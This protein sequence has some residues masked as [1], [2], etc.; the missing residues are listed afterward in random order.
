VISAV[1]AVQCCHYHMYKQPFFT[2]ITVKFW[3]VKM[4]TEVYDSA[5]ML[6]HHSSNQSAT[7]TASI[8]AAISLQHTQRHSHS[9][10]HATTVSATAVISLQ[11]TQRQSQQ[12]SVCNTPS[13]IVTPWYML[14]LHHLN[15]SQHDTLIYNQT[16][17]PYS[18]NNQ[19]YIQTPPTQFCCTALNDVIGYVILH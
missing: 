13:V 9:V 10:I 15:D 18:F 1:L 11:H 8:T 5:S 17:T 4:Q 12:Q 16:E 19:S 3:I 7:H 2:L 14:V 6:F